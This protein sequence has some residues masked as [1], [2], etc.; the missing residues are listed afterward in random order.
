M[1]LKYDGSKRP[2]SHQVVSLPL[3][4]TKISFSSEASSVS[5]LPSEDGNI[6]DFGGQVSMSEQRLSQFRGTFEMLSF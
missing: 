3:R 1:Y 6:L 2:T 5:S 4:R